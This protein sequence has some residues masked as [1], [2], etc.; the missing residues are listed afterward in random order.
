MTSFINN[1]TTS[2]DC[3]TLRDLYP[4]TVVMQLFQDRRAR[5]VDLRRKLQDA[6]AAKLVASKAQTH[7][8]TPCGFLGK[9]AA[10]EKRTRRLE[11]EVA[12]LKA[13]EAYRVG[14]FVTWPLRKAWGGVKCLRENG[15]KYTVKHAV[16]KVLRLFGWYRATY[17]C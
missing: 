8:T 10:L 3:A 13:S 2:Y 12:D 7:E 15:V 16:G 6:E 17:L 9:A 5:I 1:V 14:M 11:R 4:M